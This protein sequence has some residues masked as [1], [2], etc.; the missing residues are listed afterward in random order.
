MIELREVS[1]TYPKGNQDVHALREITLRCGTGEFVAIQGP[2]GSGKSTLLNLIGLL[3]DPT[4]GV[5]HLNGRDTTTL[6]RREKARLRGR[7][8]GFVFQSFNL[9]AHLTAWQNVAL[10]LYYAGIRKASRRQSAL[11]ALEQVILSNR[12]DHRPSELSGGE[13]Q[14]VAIARSLVMNPEIVLADE[15]TGNL[16]SENGGAIMDRLQEVNNGGVSVL[17]VSHDPI[18]VSFAHRILTLRDGRM[19]DDRAS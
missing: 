11:A 8:I 5:I 4:R 12:A 3:D 2:S 13:E 1:K 9:I 7:K 19:H 6:S 17:I 18:V 16:D 15:P 14:R 10:P